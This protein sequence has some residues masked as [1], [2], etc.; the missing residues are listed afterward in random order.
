MATVVRKK[1]SA[2][3]RAVVAGGKQMAAGEF[4]AKCL[5]LI[6]DVHDTG[7]E[8]IITKRGEP[9][10]KLVPFRP[11]KKDPFFGRLKGIIEIVGDPDD[12][13]KPVFPLEDYDMLK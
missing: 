13:I 5:G 10:A 9:K 7:L 11:P 2:A 4:K 8:V 1:K 6:D 12:L 3:I